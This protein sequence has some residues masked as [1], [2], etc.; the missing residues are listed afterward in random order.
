MELSFVLEQ[1]IREDDS[2]LVDALLTKLKP[3]DYELCNGELIDGVVYNK[4]EKIIK[5]Y[6]WFYVFNLENLGETSLCVNCEGWWGVTKEVRDMDKSLLLAIEKD[7]LDL[8]I[9]MYQSRQEQVNAEING[10]LKEYE[11]AQ[12]LIA[13]EQ[14]E[15]LEEI[16]DV[17]W[18]T[19]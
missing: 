7:L 8:K 16:R 3:G 5:W 15:E 10:T 6:R 13:L 4:G 2:C 1:E 14:W 9:A 19:S 18:E 11:E 17:G 12:R